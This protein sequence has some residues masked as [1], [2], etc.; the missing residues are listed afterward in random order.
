VSADRVI[1]CG[2]AVRHLWEFLDQGLEDDD[3]RAVE[4][5]LAFCM[6]C[7]GELAFAREL[8]RRLRTP[9]A[10]ELP[11]DIAERLGRF[12]DDLRP[13]EPGGGMA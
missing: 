13:G 12:I 7:C 8:R 11:G 2:E 3:Q 9:G 1:G 4:A 10:G 6:R 5:H